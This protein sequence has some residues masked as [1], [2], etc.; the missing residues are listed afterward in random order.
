MTRR[1]NEQKKM[2]K[3]PFHLSYRGLAVRVTQ[4]HERIAQNLS[5]TLVKKFKLIL[6]SIIKFNWIYELHYE[7]HETY[8]ICVN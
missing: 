2:E 1:F 7:I 4:L 3:N 6:T 8:M 5:G